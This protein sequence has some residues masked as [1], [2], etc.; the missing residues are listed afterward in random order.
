MPVDIEVPVKRKAGRPHGSIGIKKRKAL[1][2]GLPPVPKQKRGANLKGRL[3][4]VK[5]KKTR[6]QE[7]MREGFERKLKQDF[8][9]VLG[10]VVDRAMDGD[11][12]AAKMLI[13]RA[14]PM[15]KSIDMGDLDK[16]K[17]FEININVGSLEEYRQ[18]AI[19]ATFTEED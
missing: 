6:F 11:M 2:A 18:D 15:S 1:A 14:V 7:I 5:N 10:V 4:G 8:Y 9:K 17:G 19:E 3:P 16:G 12:V 13:D